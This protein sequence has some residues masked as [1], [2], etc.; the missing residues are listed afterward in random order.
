MRA[1][2]ILTA[3]LLGLA[4][5][6]PSVAAAAG[7][8]AEDYSLLGSGGDAKGG[9]PWGASLAVHLGLG[10][11]FDTEGTE[12]DASPT[13]GVTPVLERRFGPNFALGFEW[14]FLWVKGDDY[15]GDRS[16]LWAPHVRA[17]IS[18]PVYPKVEV[19]AM[20]GVGLGVLLPDKGDTEIAFPSYRFAFG[21]SYQF[22]PTVRA[23]GDIGYMGT[24][25]TTKVQVNG[26][27]KD[28]ETKFG[29][30]LVSAGLMA[31]F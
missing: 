22:A 8:R 15:D 16:K 28:F 11:T 24:A 13:L 17:R 27:D 29:T 5:M 3:G 18:F 26:K 7:P 14:M 12:A 4:L 19:G 9:E 23:F 2:T 1:A 31:V 6:V 25:W 10:G 21:G 30:V 20:M